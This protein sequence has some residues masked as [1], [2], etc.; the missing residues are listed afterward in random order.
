MQASPTLHHPTPAENPP[1][2]DRDEAPVVPEEVVPEGVRRLE[3]C[4]L[5]AFPVRL[6]GAGDQQHEAREGEKSDEAEKF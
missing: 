4:V 5:Q 3:T 6:E 2:P 1:L